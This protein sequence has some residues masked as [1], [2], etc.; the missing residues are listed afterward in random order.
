VL[1]A[2]AG[3]ERELSTVREQACPGQARDDPDDGGKE[4][5]SSSR[6]PRCHSGRQRK[7]KPATTARSRGQRLVL[8][9][10]V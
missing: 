7:R 10:P 9:Q 6:Y 1:R 5:V 3:G 4:A 2:Q 8:V